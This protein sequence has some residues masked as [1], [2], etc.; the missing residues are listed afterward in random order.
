M[1]RQATINAERAALKATM[2]P[3]EVA[4]LEVIEECSAKLEAAGVPFQLWAAHG[5]GEE[6]NGSRPFWW[7]F[8]KLSYTPLENVAA[9]SDRV[10]EAWRSLISRLLTHQTTH[11]QISIVLYNGH[12]GAPMSVH[13]NGTVQYVPPPPSSLPSTEQS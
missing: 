2:S 1:A 12:T 4:R 5:D 7:C 9:Y 11:G 6:G 13:S 3:T 8:H 10:F